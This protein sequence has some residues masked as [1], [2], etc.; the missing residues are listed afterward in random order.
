MGKAS[1]WKDREYFDVGLDEFMVR[2][3][4]YDERGLEHWG[5]IRV[6]SKDKAARRLD[7]VGEITKSIEGGSLPGEVELS[8]GVIGY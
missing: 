5:L 2:V 6:A 3:S 8:E 4:V 7:A 1:H